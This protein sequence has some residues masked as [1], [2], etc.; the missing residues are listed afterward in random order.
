MKKLKLIVSLFVFCVIL[1]ST[2]TQCFAL[3]RVVPEKDR[4]AIITKYLVNQQ[5]DPVEGIWSWTVNGS[6][7][8]VAII[9]N[10]SSSVYPEAKYLG[11]TLDNGFGSIGEAKL[12]L[13]QSAN[14]SVYPGAYVVQGSFGSQNAKIANYVMVSN[15]LIQATVPDRD[16]GTLSFVRMDNFAS[17]PPVIKGGTG[18]GFFI[19]NSNFAP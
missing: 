11:V 13:H 2:T 16:I 14:G 6:S 19:T 7:G 10:P 15:A 5:L 18:T 8:E 3:K 17:T 9:K 4:N 1:V 12:I